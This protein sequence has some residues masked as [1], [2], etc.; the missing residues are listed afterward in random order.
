[1]R[2]IFKTFLTLAVFGVFCY[3]LYL[4]FGGAWSSLYQKFFPCQSPIPYT[5]GTF[6]PRFGISQK[7]FL[8]DAA[9]AEAIW[10]KPQEF[11]GKNFFVYKPG[12]TDPNVLKINLVYDYREQATQ[13]INSLGG[14]VS[15]T[16]ASYESLKVQYAIQQQQYLQEQSEFQAK[17]TAYNNDPERSSGQ[18]QEMEAMQADLNIKVNDIN[19]LVVQINALAQALNINAQ[20]VNTIGASVGEEFTE[21]EYK[22]S[23]SGR[24]IDVYEFSTNDKLVRL[25]THE[26]GHALGLGHVTDPNAIMY[27]LNQNKSGTLTQ[28]DI[29]ELKA[30]C[31]IK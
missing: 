9:K 11:Q 3:V 15:V 23:A 12:N 28:A 18:R 13:K 16:R 25:L 8:V 24:E 5:I 26:F 4:N 29:D 14:A 30:V 22:E 20:E 2:K 17:L 6:D 1:M 31:K 19:N 27:Y 7:D 21:G 10:E